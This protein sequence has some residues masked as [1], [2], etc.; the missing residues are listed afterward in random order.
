LTTH[1]S[2]DLNCRTIYKNQLLADGILIGEKATGE[3][4]IDN[5]R[6]GR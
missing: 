3:S 1:D 6:G 4:L 2:D 5:Q